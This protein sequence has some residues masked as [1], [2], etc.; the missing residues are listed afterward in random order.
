MKKALIALLGVIC[1]NIFAASFTLPTSKVNFN[2][3][4]E[5]EVVTPVMHVECSRECMATEAFEC[6]ATMNTHTCNEFVVNGKPIKG[7]AHRELLIRTDKNTF[8]L[9]KLEANY[10]GVLNARICVRLETNIY[11]SEL[12]N[13]FDAS[14]ILSYCTNRTSSWEGHPNDV[15]YSVWNNRRTNSFEELMSALERPID[16][17]LK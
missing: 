5:R 12:E 3:N 8:I 9:P 6:V 17:R 13:E 4:K 2:P 14:S 15:K 10:Q 7:Y 11:S 1:S 16:V